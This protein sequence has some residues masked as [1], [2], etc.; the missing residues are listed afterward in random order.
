[1]ATGESHDGQMIFNHEAIEEYEFI[2]NFSLP[3]T[4]PIWSFSVD[5]AINKYLKNP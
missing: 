5:K 4:E 1:M 3:S 2:H